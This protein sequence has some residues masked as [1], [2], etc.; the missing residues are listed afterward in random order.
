MFES[1]Q[2]APLHRDKLRGIVG[3]YIDN[4]RKETEDWVLLSLEVVSG[5]GI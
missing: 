2:L 3:A 1:V 4:P 5:G